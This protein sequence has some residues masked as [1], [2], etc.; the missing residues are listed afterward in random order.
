MTT[1]D[2]DGL[3]SASLLNLADHLTGVLAAGAAHDRVV[4]DGQARAALTWQ[5]EPLVLLTLERDLLLEELQADVE[6]IDPD[7]PPEAGRKPP[8]SSLRFAPFSERGAMLPLWPLAP[9]PSFTRLAVSVRLRSVAEGGSTTAVRPEDVAGSLSLTVVEGTTGR[10]LFLCAA[11]KA[12]IRRAA[13]EVATARVLACA[14]RAS[15]DRHGADLGVARFTDELT[16]Q[17]GP[18][19]QIFTAPRTDRALEGDLDYRRR[20]AATRTFSLPTPAD[21]RAAINGDGADTDPARGWLA[22]LAPPGAGGVPAAPHRI[23]VTEEVRPFS[24]GLLLLSAASDPATAKNA[25]QAFLERIRTERLVLPATGTDTDTAYARR[26]L[27]TAQR[28]DLIALGEDLRRGFTFQGSQQPGLAPGLAR[29]LQLFALC[30]T[31]LGVA[32]PWILVRSQDQSGGSVYE[33]GLAADV[34]PPADAEQALAAKLE[35]WQ[36]TTAT[37]PAVRASLTIAQR[38]LGGERG[39]SDLILSACGA[40][41]LRRLSEPA[42]AIR[43]SHL[44]LVE[45]SAEGGQDVV[46]RGASHL[47]AFGTTPGDTPLQ[48]VV[49]ADARAGRL[50]VLSLDPQGRPTQVAVKDVSPPVAEVA[51]L[52]E[53]AGPDPSRVGRVALLFR[54]DPAAVPARPARFQVVAVTRSPEGNVSIDASTEGQ[55]LPDWTHVVP[56]RWGATAALALHDR[57][58]SALVVQPVDGQPAPAPIEGIGRWT[59]LF[60]MPA[61]RRD[62]A[63]EGGADDVGADDAGGDDIACYDATSGDVQVLAVRRI[64]NGRADVRVRWRRDAWGPGLDLLAALPDGRVLAVDRDLGRVEE[65]STFAGGVPALTAHHLI[66][67]RAVTHVAVLPA[68][69]ITGPAGVVLAYDRARGTATLWKDVGPRGP[70]P[71]P[72]T[73]WDEE[74]V[75]VAVTADLSPD[76]GTRPF[77]RA[78]ATAAAGWRELGHQAFDVVRNTDQHALWSP[79]EAEPLARVFTGIGLAV[80]GAG[81]DF[82]ERAKKLPAAE[83]ATIRVDDATARS[84][85]AGDGRKLAVDLLQ[86]LSVPGIASAVAVNS[87][88]PNRPVVVVSSRSLPAGGLNVSG[89]RVSGVRW[90][91]LPVTGPPAAVDGDEDGGTARPAGDGISMLVALGYRTS[92]LADPYQVRL[93]L[94]DGDRLTPQQY[95]FLMNVVERAVPAGIEANTFAIRRRHLDLDGDGTADPLPVAAARVF[96]RFR[97]SA[98]RARPESP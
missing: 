61:A 87:P 96:R 84:W 74:P 42:G 26:L 28:K 47:G 8:V 81:S 2:P 45:V 68:S 39:A 48:L 15:L 7:H 60:P 53:P 35:R 70:V 94:A 38:A 43:V 17:V 66:G 52:R 72:N 57:S 77:D 29:C 76:D 85:A 3:R 44:S 54:G 41:T 18:P 33:L 25:R 34:V 64:G 31:E 65:W 9:L 49:T 71:R 79:S 58:R 13:R 73:G 86:V 37:P 22:E 91:A 75:A 67:P 1:V 6:L 78:L 20:L 90:D 88:V 46:P 32:A 51:V 55:G 11:E 63:E 40:R 97:S 59:H 93:D 12:A 23:R 5:R 95:E 89:R 56:F 98:R 27:T 80:A 24:V 21:V 16:G 19:P 50:M 62:G 69:P 36:P 82:V 30:R 92:E 83:V 4:L 14:R 10:I